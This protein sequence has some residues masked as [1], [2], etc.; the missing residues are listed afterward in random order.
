MRNTFKEE[1]EKLPIDIDALDIYDCFTE[2]G[3]ECTE[4]FYKVR[5]TNEDYDVGFPFDEVKR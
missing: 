3:I 1:S 4:E 2:N 5:G